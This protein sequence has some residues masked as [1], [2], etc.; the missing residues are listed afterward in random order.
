MK[1]FKW[2]RQP[3]ADR[4]TAS[5]LAIDVEF[6]LALQPNAAGELLRGL[7]AQL[8]FD[9]ILSFP[10]A[11]GCIREAFIS[12]ETSL[13]I[14]DLHTANFFCSCLQ[15]MQAAIEQTADCSLP[16]QD[17]Q[18]G[19]QDMTSIE[20]FYTACG[21]SLADLIPAVSLYTCSVSC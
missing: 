4:H 17:L 9:A 10:A 12:T 16:E 19:A 18:S 6:K 15:L 8:V 21:V 13:A 5:I 7:V 20:A 1:S 11:V 3:A 2:P 14:T